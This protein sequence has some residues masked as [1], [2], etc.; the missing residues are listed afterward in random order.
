[1]IERSFAQHRAEM[2]EALAG[3]ALEERRALLPLLR[4][5]GRTAEES[6]AKAGPK[7]KSSS[8]GM[9][10]EALRASR[11]GARRSRE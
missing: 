1:M 5:L 2:E 4:R 9:E 11:R 8:S 3:F 10:K 7:I 6:T